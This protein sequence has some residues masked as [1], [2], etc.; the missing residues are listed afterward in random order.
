MRAVMTYLDQF[1]QSMSAENS[2]SKYGEST[3]RLED[4]AR[5]EVGEKDLAK[6]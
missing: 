4:I 1:E 2:L 6:T 3:T 5:K